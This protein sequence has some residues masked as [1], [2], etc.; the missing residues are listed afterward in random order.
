MA[1]VSCPICA[2]ETVP[3]VAAGYRRAPACTH[4]F[5]AAPPLAD[6][7]ASVYGDDYFTAG[8]AG[9]SDY[10]A[11]GA[12]LRE[13]GRTYGRLLTATRRRVGS[14]LDIGAAAGFLLAGFEDTGWSGIGVEPNATVCA[15]GRTHLRSEERRV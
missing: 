5:L 12:L 6:H 7:L 13:R 8:G 4:A 15:Y 10:L 14:I 2:S 1:I 11:E 3:L 9:Y